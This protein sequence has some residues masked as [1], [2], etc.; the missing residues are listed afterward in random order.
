MSF[1]SL[2]Y[3]DTGLAGQFKHAET[4]NYFDY[5]ELGADEWSPEF[6]GPW[7]KFTRANAKIFVGPTGE[8][9]RYAYVAKTRAYVVVDEEDFGDR[10]VVER[11]NIKEH[12]IFKEAQK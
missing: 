2:K 3:L 8:E 5:V 1:A 4:G 12:H 9:T 7:A 6:R 10:W 11:W